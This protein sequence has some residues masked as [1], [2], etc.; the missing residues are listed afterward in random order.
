M[1]WNWSS[2]HVIQN[3][4]HSKGWCD[5]IGQLAWKK[6]TFHFH[7]KVLSLCSLLETIVVF[8]ITSGLPE[9]HKL[10][11]SVSLLTGWQIYSPKFSSVLSWKVACIRNENHFSTRAPSLWNR[12]DNNFFITLGYFSISWRLHK[13]FSICLSKQ[14]EMKIIFNKV[15]WSQCDR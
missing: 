7:R 10:L 12:L 6:T 8:W 5:R 15:Q 4:Y 11:C 3:V 1:N 2:L 13:M 9:E 14:T